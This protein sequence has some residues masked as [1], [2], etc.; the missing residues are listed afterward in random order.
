MQERPLLSCHSF[1]SWASAVEAL[2]P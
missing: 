2:F 1:L